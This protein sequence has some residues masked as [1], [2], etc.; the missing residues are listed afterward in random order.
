MRR[1]VPIV[2]AIVAFALMGGALVRGEVFSIRDHVGYFQPMRWFTALELRSFRLPLWNPYSAAGEPWLANPQTGIFYPPAWLFVVLPFASAYVLYP[3][4]HALL[5][6]GGAYAL[7]ARRVPEPAALLGAVALMVC[8]PVLS[9]V[10]VS[11]NFTTLA[12]LP[13]VLWCAVTEA[14]PRLSAAVIALSFLAGEPF[15]AALGALA[16]AALRWRAP[17]ALAVTAAGA[18]GLVAVQLLPFLEMLQGSDRR[19]GMTADM[20]LRDS[21]APGDWLRIA[22]PPRLHSSVIDAHLHQQF[23]PIVYC[24]VIVTGLAVLAL[25]TSFRRRDVQL[26]L[27]VILGIAFLAAG[28]YFEPVAWMWVHLPVKVLR[29]PARLVALATIPLA[30]LAAVGW[31]WASR[32]VTWRWLAF[33]VIAAVGLDGVAHTQPLFSSH[34]FQPNPVPHP[35]AVAR[36]G[37]FIRLTSAAFIDRGAWIDGYINLLDRRFD[38]TTPAP[39]T[40]ARYNDVYAR[41]VDSKTLQGLAMMSVRYVLAEHLTPPFI[42]IEST[43][44]VTAYLNRR[45]LPIAYFRSD[46]GRYGPIDFL[47]IGTSF[48]RI[49]VDAAAPGLV[50]ITQQDAPGWEV[51]VD[52]KRTR[53]TTRIDGVFRAVHVGSGRHAIE[54]TYR[55]LSLR[56][57]AAISLLALVWLSFGARAMRPARAFVKR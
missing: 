1:S 14:G 42:P 3:I 52:G 36:D 30:L 50:V 33:A 39:V 57:G 43:H 25:V 40:N 4:L 8:G 7:F 12:W 19:A 5:L 11:N 46:A 49:S 51:S 13:L 16:F 22:V 56:V 47:S 20:L 21:M 10:D 2:I 29:Y 9:L 45:A 27:G 32:R 48:A 53:V 41:A 6:G 55:P 54:W 31:E 44:G 26:A 23:L 35:L 34:R 15:F 24:G 28:T 18:A 38:A 17:R 37:Y